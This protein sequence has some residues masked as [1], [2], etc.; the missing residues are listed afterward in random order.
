[1]DY[2]AQKEIEEW[3]AKVNLHVVTDVGAYVGYVHDIAQQAIYG[4][5]DYDGLQPQNMYTVD[6]GF[7]FA[8]QKGGYAFRSVYDPAADLYHYD[9]YI[10]GEG[11]KEQIDNEN[12]P[13]VTTTGY[14][15]DDA[16]PCMVLFIGKGEPVSQSH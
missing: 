9:G 7:S 5:S 16:V 13:F 1:M 8:K 14:L 4:C 15:E 6:S 12:V 2:L 10:A 11:N 3:L